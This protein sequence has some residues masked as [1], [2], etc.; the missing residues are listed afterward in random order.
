MVADRE[1]IAPGAP[2]IL[3]VFAHPDD[4]VFVAGARWRNTPPPGCTSILGSKL[5]VGIGRG[6][7]PKGRVSG[8]RPPG[9]AQHPL[10]LPGG[11]WA[12][13]L[14]R[15]VGHAHQGGAGGQRR[16]A[17]ALAAVA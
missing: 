10:R 3:G 8:R 6:P 11:V 17:A 9:I 5:L 4:E 7:M 12:A 13:G 2:R 16:R 1:T 14:H 15:F